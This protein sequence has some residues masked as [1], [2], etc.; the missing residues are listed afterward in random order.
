LKPFTIQA[1]KQQY[2]TTNV[3]HKPTKPTQ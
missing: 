3:Q 2:K 1:K